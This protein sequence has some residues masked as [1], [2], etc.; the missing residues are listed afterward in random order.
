M[1][2]RQIE[3]RLK[4]MEALQAQADALGEQIDA[5]KAEIQTA[6]GDTEEVT[7]GK[8][9][10]FWKWRKA[11]TRFDT[12][13]FKAEHADMYKAFTVETAPTRFWKVTEA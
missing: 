8:Y 5:L 3:N 2:N 4:K 7:A 11:G 1:T 10:V 12:K 9:H 13:R 6:L